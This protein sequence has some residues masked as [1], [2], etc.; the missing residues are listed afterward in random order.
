MEVKVLQS[1][2]ANENEVSLWCIHFAS[3][4][5]K[6]DTLVPEIVPVNERL[7]V[8]AKDKKEAKKKMKKEIF[9]LR[10]QCKGF[11]ALIR[12]SLVNIENLVIVG[13]YSL[14]GRMHSIS[15]NKL[16]PAILSCEEDRKKYRLAASLI[17]LQ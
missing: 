7:L 4:A 10:K 12:A 17:P 13:H 5:K 15:A 8:V 9:Q 11:K 16:M 2:L 3:Y 1:V 14:D 6:Y